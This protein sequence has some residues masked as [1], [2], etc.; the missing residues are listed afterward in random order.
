MLHKIKFQCPFLEGYCSSKTSESCTGYK[1]FNVVT[2]PSKRS[3]FKSNLRRLQ[4]PNSFEKLH[5]INF[6]D[7]TQDKISMSL[8][9]I[10]AKNFC[11]KNKVR[12]ETRIDNDDT[13]GCCKGFQK[14]Q[15]YSSS[16]TSE[17]CTG[18]KHFNV[19]TGPSKRSTF[20]SNLRRLQLPNSF[21]KLHKI[22]FNDVTQDKISM[23]LF[24]ILAKNFCRKNKV[25]AETRIDNDDTSGCC[26][27]FQKFQGY[28]SSKTSESCTGYKHFNVVTGPSKRSTFKSNLRRLQL[29]NS[30][31]KLHKINFNDVTQDKISM[32]LFRRLQQ[33]KNF[34]KLHRIQTFQCCY[35]T[36]QEVHI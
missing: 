30:F 11:R 22:N 12:A 17:S 5:K 24:R 18:Y 21:E 8:F 32:S 13:S 9:R 27:G 7:V 35:R 28:S 1:H 4:L 36:F 14:F 2:G 31:E 19:V 26:K 10:L 16:K 29:P 6:N 33:P 15:G 25:R 20:K 3:T 34:G 23:S